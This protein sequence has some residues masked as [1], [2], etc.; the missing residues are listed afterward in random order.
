MHKTTP[1]FLF[2]SPRLLR[3]E[4]NECCKTDKLKFLIFLSGG[5]IMFEVIIKYAKAFF[6]IFS[7]LLFFVRSK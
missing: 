6:G 3:D 4:Y 2:K 7:G 1:R 5:K